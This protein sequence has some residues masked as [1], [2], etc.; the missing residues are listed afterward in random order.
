MRFKT[1]SL[2]EWGE[3]F[4][5]LDAKT[6]LLWHIPN[7]R[8]EAP[9]TPHFSGCKPCKQLYK[10][11]QQLS[12]RVNILTEKQKESRKAV[13]S[14]YGL[15]FL[16]PASQ[17]TRLTRISQ[18]RIRLQMKIDKLQPY[19]CNLKDTQ[20]A[21]MLKLV[22]SVN[23][24]SH[25]IEELCGRGDDVL[26]SDK[27]LLRAAWKQEV[28]DRLEYEKDQSRTGTCTALCAL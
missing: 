15:K 12:K 21:E 27:N 17:K 18:E 7:Q 10:A 1:K 20:H 14:N 26:G 19:D 8:Q 28:V 23:K 4:H 13:S 3:P 2:R 22:A 24:D 16:S 25:T 5:R 6:C 9:G 11:V